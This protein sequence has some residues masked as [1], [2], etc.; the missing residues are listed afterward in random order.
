[1]SGAVGDNNLSGNK[2]F[3]PATDLRTELED[4]ARSR[5]GDKDWGSSV[6]I[7]AQTCM[8]GRE[9]SDGGAYAGPYAVSKSRGVEAEEP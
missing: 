8:R 5:V 6:N 2:F 1:M 9:S 7:I 4:G 3:I